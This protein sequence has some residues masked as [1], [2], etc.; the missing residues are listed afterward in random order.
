M[1]HVIPTVN[2][3]SQLVIMKVPTRD[4]IV[5]KRVKDVNGRASLRIGVEVSSKLM[6]PVLNIKIIDFN[7]Q[8]IPKQNR[9]S[10]MFEP[11]ELLIAMLANPDL[12]T[13]I[14][15]EINSGTDVPA[16]KIVRPAT[17]SGRPKV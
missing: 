7:N 8:G 2:P 13:T 9:M 5:I 1:L 3:N 14:T 10:K 16:A 6:L 17:V 12:F 4:K 11:I 15:L